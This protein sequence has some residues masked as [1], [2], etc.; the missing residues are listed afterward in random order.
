M[1]YVEP[2]EGMSAD[3]LRQKDV[4]VDE[5]ESGRPHPGERKG[6]LAQGQRTLFR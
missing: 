4:L 6:D 1:P 2:V 5:K 3:V